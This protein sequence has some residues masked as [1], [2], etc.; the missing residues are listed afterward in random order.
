MTQDPLPEHDGRYAAGTEVTLVASPSAHYE[1]KDTP[2]LAFVSWSGAATGG[3]PTINILMDGDK[4]V[5]A[6]F[7]EFFPPLCTPTPT[8]TVTPTPTA[9]P[10]PI[11]LPIILR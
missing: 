6:N 5:T 8:P 3:E 10:Q 9:T 11:Y 7:A 4:A 2:Y 1:C